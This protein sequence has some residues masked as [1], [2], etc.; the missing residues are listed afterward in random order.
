MRQ[1]FD[2]KIPLVEGSNPVNKR[3]YRYAKNQKDIIHSLVKDY[4]KS[5]II[6]KSNSPFASLV[7]LVGKKDGSWQLC[8]DY[9]DLNKATIKDKFPI[10]LVEDL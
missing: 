4:L 10:P 7:A 2:H 5:G 8:V 3:A 1:G 6:Q 9:R